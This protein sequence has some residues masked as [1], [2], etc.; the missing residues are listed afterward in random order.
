MD[1]LALSCVTFSLVHILID[2]SLGGAIVIV[3]GDREGRRRDDHD[4]MRRRASR[5]LTRRLLRREITPRYETLHT[6]GAPGPPATSDVRD[7]DD[8]WPCAVSAGSG[9]GGHGGC[10]LMSFD[11]LW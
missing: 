10:R 3:H 2:Y 8:G 6:G 1:L 5:R 7:I 9:S 11:G 4:S